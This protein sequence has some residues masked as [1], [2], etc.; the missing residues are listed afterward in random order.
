MTTQS[1]PEQAGGSL[2]QRRE[3]CRFRRHR[4]LQQIGTATVG[5]REVGIPGILH[6]LTIRFFFLKTS[7]GWP[8]DKRP[9]NR[10]VV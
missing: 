2:N 7:F 3:T 4:P 9:D 5:R 6:G 10:R 1:I 8:G